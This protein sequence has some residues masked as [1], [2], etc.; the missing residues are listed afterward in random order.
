MSS[1]VPSF[2]TPQ[3]FGQTHRGEATHLY[4]LTIADR[5][6]VVV[7]DFGG[8][9]TQIWVP[10]RTGHF[11]DV[12]LGFHELEPYETVS[13]YFGALIGRVGNRI[14]KGRF[15]LNNTTY[16]VATNNA[17]GGHPCH[18]HGGLEGFDKAVWKVGHYQ[19]GGDEPLLVLHHRSS[20]GDEGYP[21]N[22]Q[23]TVTYRLTPE[24]ALSIEYQAV[25][26]ATTLVNMTNHAYFNLAGESSGHVLDHELEIR[27]KAI[28]AV[29]EGLIP[30]GELLE[31]AGTPFD[32]STPKPIGQDI[33]QEDL[34]LRRAGG[35]DHN[36]VL[37]GDDGSLRQVA[38]A[39]EP[40][41]GRVLETYTTEPG[42]QFYSGNFL[43][44]SILG[45]QGRPYEKHAGFCLETQHF[46]DA[47]HHPEFPSIVL[48]PDE[49]Y[50]SQTIYRFTTR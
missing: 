48:R 10:D 16:A 42:M 20:D 41:S 7:S 1:S 49:N 31:V 8:I 43:D 37:E 36:F 21:G 24:G 27:A 4:C 14:A 34:Q 40:G 2:T 29:D 26:D 28:T 25:T 19:P 32:F 5:L 45:K 47:P 44:G 22:L 38:E 17:P 46:P 11:D 3:P 23:V 13:P 39:Y 33:A 15:D 18:L 35:Y 30:T 50:R 6:T 9:L 12:V